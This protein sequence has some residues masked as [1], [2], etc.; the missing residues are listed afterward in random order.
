MVRWMKE[1]CVNKKSGGQACCFKESTTE[2]LIGEGARCD[3][4]LQAQEYYRWDRTIE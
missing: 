3:E 4:P 2:S 1:K